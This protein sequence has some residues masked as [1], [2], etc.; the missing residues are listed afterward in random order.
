MNPLT[1][2][3]CNYRAYRAQF[4]CLL[5]LSLVLPCWS[6]LAESV[7]EMKKKGAVYDEKFQPTEALKFYLPAEKLSPSDAKLLL[8]IA[9]QYRHLM[10][11]ASTRAE[12]ISLGCT[13]LYYAQRATALA[14]NEAE[15]HLSIAISHAKM[16]SLWDNKQKMESSRQVKISVDKAIELDPSL[17]QAW[18]ILG[19]WHQR[20]A[21]ISVVK[22]SLAKLIYGGV[23]KASNDESV[24][25]L[26]KAIE[27]NPSRLI[28]FIELGCTYAQM[29]QKVEAR[30][31]IEKGLAMP[32]VGKDDPETKKRGREILKGL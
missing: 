19:C 26:K 3:H 14:P 17:D 25:C 16:V 24:R 22:K 8:S 20:L 13:G 5:L 32:D 23:P 30:Q 28:H 29:G 7:A 10:A 6:G 27:L 2:P 11:D 31:F 21:T 4:C 15:A 9:R 18:H 1:F 12:K